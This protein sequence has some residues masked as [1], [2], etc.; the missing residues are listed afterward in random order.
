MSKLTY[1]SR[2]G[3]GDRLGWSAPAKCLRVGR[4]GEPDELVKL[5]LGDMLIL[6][7]HLNGPRPVHRITS[8]CTT[9]GDMRQSHPVGVTRSRALGRD[10][11]GMGRMGMGRMGRMGR[12]GRMG[13]MG[14]VGR[15][16]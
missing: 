16:G 3:S 12:T 2:G 9:S 7:D 8:D 5:R 6:P 15:I 11:H 14:R 13:R 10:A 4:E 1:T